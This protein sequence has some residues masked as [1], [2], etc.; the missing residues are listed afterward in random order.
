MKNLIL[1]VI[2]LVG[3]SG[4]AVFYQPAP[5]RIHGVYH[6]QIKDWQKRVQEQGWSRTRVDDVVKGSLNLVLYEPEETD[7][8]DTPQEFISKGFKG[9]CEDI[10][11]F[12]MATLKRLDYPHGV[13]ILGVKTLMGDHAVLKVEL[14]DGQWKMYE[15]VPVPLIEVDQLFYRPIVEFDEKSIV[16]YKNTAAT[17]T[18]GLAR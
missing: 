14:P 6:D 12:I 15:T 8:W 9:D 2:L 4:C 13:R 7:H 16:Y 3:A 5:E 17:E 10:A 11:V 18:N 1:I